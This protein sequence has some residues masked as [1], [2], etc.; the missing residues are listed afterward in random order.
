MCLAGLHSSQSAKLPSWRGPDTFFEGRLPSNRND[1]G[2]SSCD[3]GR[4]YVFGGDAGQDGELHAGDEME[5]RC[6]GTRSG[7]A[8]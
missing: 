4:I 1:H 3:D 8:V 2:F 5:M 6:V 7:D